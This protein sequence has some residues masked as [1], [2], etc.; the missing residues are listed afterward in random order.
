MKKRKIKFGTPKILFDENSL[1]FVL[2]ALGYRINE[3]GLIT[4]KKD[5]PV[6]SPEGEEVFAYQ[7][8]AIQKG[9][10]KGSILFIKNDLHSLMKYADGEYDNR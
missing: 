10:R 2:E 7:L 4:D 9:K 8:G 5:E 1:S 6:L 3:T